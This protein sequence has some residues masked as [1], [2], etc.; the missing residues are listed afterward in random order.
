VAV[1]TLLPRIHEILLNHPGDCAAWMASVMALGASDETRFYQ[2]LNSRRM[3]GGA[4]SIACQA[5][6]DNPAMD[7]QAW[8]AEIREFRELMIEL[9]TLLQARGNAHPDI[10]SWLLAFSNWNQ[11][12][13]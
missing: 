5:L 1:Q 4:G 11:S 12:G 7:E 3:W 9:G 10:A 8:L 2:E 6:A 13:V